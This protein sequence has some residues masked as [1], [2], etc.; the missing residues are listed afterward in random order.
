MKRDSRRATAFGAGTV[1]FW[2]LSLLAWPAA[3]PVTA[4]EPLGSA[5]DAGA[6]GLRPIAHEDVWLAKRPGAPTLSPDGRWAVL[7]VMEPAYDPSDQRTDLWIVATDGSEAPRRLT[8][9]RGSEAG[10]TW[11]PDGSRLAFSTRR[12]GDDASQI[13]VL[14]L[15]RGG[16]A[17]RV[18]SLATG[19]RSPR[20]SPDGSAI[21]FT[22][23][24]LREAQDLAV[25]E[26]LMEEQR[27]QKHRARV[28]D[29]FPIRNWDRWLEDTRPRLF[30]QR[31]AE[32]AE[33]RDLLAGAALVGQAG[34]AGPGDDLSARWT[35]D[36]RGVVF[37]AT[38]EQDRAAHAPF[39]WHLYHVALEGGEPRRLTDGPD[40]YGNPAFSPDGRHL[41]A[42]V[43]PGTEFVYNLNRLAALSW[44]DPGAVRVLTAEWDRSVSDFEPSP[45]GRTLF[46]LAED[47]GHDRIWTM[48]AAGGAVRPL[49]PEGVGV[50]GGLSVAGSSRAPVLVARWESAVSPPELVR[51]DVRN[52]SH[53]PLTTFNEGVLAG[54]DMPPLRSFW[55]TSEGGA[56][57][58][59]FLALPPGF[60]E[61]ERYP[62]LV[63][64]HG[65][66]H[67]AWKD[68]WVLRWNY[69]LLASP[70]YVVLLTNFTGSTG[71][72]EA[73][74]QAI[75]G[76]PLRGPAEEINQAADEAIRR[77]PFID[78]T[79][80]AA[81][82]AS[83]GGHLAYWMAG[84]TD[85]YRT[86]IAH[87]GAINM[88]S[89]WGTSDVIYHR[90][91]NFLGPVWEQ[92]PV[93]REQNP[94]RLAANFATPMLLTVGELDYRVPL[95]TTLEAWNLLQ[96]LEIPSRLVVFPTEN[97]WIMT[98]ENSRFF[99]REV[100]D[101]LA[102]WLDPV[103]GAEG[104]AR[105]R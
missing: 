5:A 52:G 54:V 73:F 2:T 20:W 69:H 63:L 80:Q 87:A 61:N 40:S 105:P 37:V 3:A 94:I 18:T 86:L 65:G 33:P 8:S 66:P 12:D 50:F 13:Y 91:V 27:A 38:E 10:V 70:G 19:A 25:H 43:N 21:L 89:Q 16:E 44:P 62:L 67:S 74:A 42:T 99:Y 88:E 31:L 81:G 93:W 60:D 92:G 72:G 51:V 58:Q 6:P 15:A 26:R 78:E 96:R 34:F 98:G 22:S 100:H 71:F 104:V 47:E 68:Q 35:P 59:S 95:N 1:L 103:D 76:D 9:G 17:Q 102:R 41:Y 53:R 48:P 49:T 36:G 7:T 45:D 4:Q 84:V 55:F 46:I 77:F 32:G 101:W 57:I 90:E 28:Y 97:H 29:G 82:G 30:V 23:T 64:M 75:Q 11:S 79:R 56:R 39:A 14:D 85:R 83:Y 24:L